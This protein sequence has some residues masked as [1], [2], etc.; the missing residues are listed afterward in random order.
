M[1]EFSFNTGNIL[2]KF[3]LLFLNLLVYTLLLICLYVMMLWGFC[4][5]LY[6]YR[7]QRIFI[8]NHR[9]Y[10]KVNLI[11]RKIA[12]LYIN[13]FHLICNNNKI[14]QKWINKKTCC[15]ESDT[16]TNLDHFQKFLACTVLYSLVLQYFAL[17]L[18]GGLLVSQRRIARGKCTRKSWRRKRSW[19]EFYKK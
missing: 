15:S 6:K 2:K 16:S 19:R 17:F 1:P 5:R 12:A 9:F 18:A 10:P 7:K 3:H 4:E 13:I 14:K 8:F 11:L